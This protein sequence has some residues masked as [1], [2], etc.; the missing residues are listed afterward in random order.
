MTF[1]EMLAGESA[2]TIGLA[3]AVS[4]AVV[5]E[6]AFLR[7]AR[8]ELERGPD[9]GVE[10]DVWFSGFV[11]SRDQD[12]I[13]FYREAADGLRRRLAQSATRRRH[14]WALL[15]QAHADT[16]P[17]LQLEEEIGWLLTDEGDQ[18]LPKIKQRLRSAIAT[19][20][21]GERIGLAHWAV[22]AIHRLPGAVL[23]LE[24]TRIL[25][26]AAR[27]RLDGSSN[28][29]DVP[30]WMSWVLPTSQRATTAIRLRMFAGVLEM[31]PAAT[32]ESSP[33]GEVIRIPT[34]E[35]LAIELDAG[36]GP[37][38]VTLPI[39][40]PTFARIG[41]GTVRL[42]ACDGAVYELTPSHDRQSQRRREIISFKSLLDEGERFAALAEPLDVL[43]SASFKAGAGL[44]VTG[45]PGSGKTG[46]LI[47][48]V[49]TLTQQ[50]LAMHF[51]SDRT[52]QWRDADLAWTSLAAQVEEF[53]PVEPMRPVRPIE[54]LRRA[55]HRLPPSN[56]PFIVVIDGLDE[57]TPASRAR[58]DLV[59][60]FGDGLPPQACVV[61]SCNDQ[62]HISEHISDGQSWR[63]EVGKP[64]KRAQDAGME[65]LLRRLFEGSSSM[66]GISLDHPQWERARLRAAQ[67]S[68]VDAR[69]AELL[70]GNFLAGHL[71]RTSRSGQEG[72]MSVLAGTLRPAAKGPQPSD[73]AVVHAVAAAVWAS[74]PV[75]ARGLLR[76]L[77]A[78]R[79]PL[80]RFRIDDAAR[81]RVESSDSTFDTIEP[82]LATG[83]TPDADT[84]YIVRHQA[85]RTFI[86]GAPPGQNDSMLE[87]HE[88][89]LNTV[90]KWTPR[91]LGEFQKEYSLRYAVTHAVGTGD[92]QRVVELLT[93][94]DF[95][96][97]RCRLE[98]PDRFVAELR[99]IVDNDDKPLEETISVS[100]ALSD[101]LVRL[102]QDPSAVRFLAYTALRSSTSE[103]K[104]TGRLPDLRLRHA[105]PAARPEG[106]EHRGAVVGCAQLGAS[107]IISWSADGTLKSWRRHDL[108]LER[109][110]TG[111]LEAVTACHMFQEGSSAAP[112]G[113]TLLSG[114]RDGTVR[115]W[116]SEKSVVVTTH[117]AP[118]RGV[119]WTGDAVLS[120]D[121]AGVIRVSEPGKGEIESVHEHRGAVNVCA[122]EGQRVWSGSEDHTIR[123]WSGL[124]N[125][126]QRDRPPSSVVLSG[127]TGAITAISVRG[128]D[129]YAYSCSEDGTIRVWNPTTFEESGLFS[130]HTSAVLGCQSRPDSTLVSWSRDRTL[131]IWDLAQERDTI[132]MTGHEGAV[133]GASVLSS[134]QILSC[135]SD[136]TLRL[137]DGET[138]AP[139]AV[140]EGHS[141]AVNGALVLDETY[142]ISCSDDRSLVRWDP[143]IWQ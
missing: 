10:A 76:I 48:F 20:V 105:I 34:I 43:R 64:L 30:E 134:G 58:T 131:R 128:P 111:H 73:V 112:S 5:I 40:R 139:L 109:T 54:R 59:E 9:A 29:T 132:V 119:T 116:Q 38:S 53:L 62:S 84:T 87:S 74:L 8:L 124:I 108:S 75:E 90:A 78:A 102:R 32:S 100:R 23:E 118:V 15:Q 71:L 57:M 31:E 120:W 13:V 25:Y 47:A 106:R 35:P 50:P 103:P 89:L 39:G 98:S 4:L 80:T 88:A 123:V 95:L 107:N 83:R 51:F 60:L 137:W 56:T 28:E 93:N 136:G 1:D 126:S 92:G 129:Q 121:A 138:G 79:E 72:L 61:C 6:P 14:A 86:E 70:G 41:N 33:P 104:V 133:L 67:E 127:H 113:L 85:L 44:F 27:L 81:S 18:A 99:A 7:R 97:A 3:E 125:K 65:P 140:F 21:G 17:A 91:D 110:L 37:V 142:I 36:D 46:L 26:T 42:R 24:E 22:Q 63:E 52:H 12:G 143:P 130:G 11:A 82:W 55:L 141:A 135:S 114:S 49:R 2:A 96:E 115:I 68:G 122:I 19:L 77:A 94:L 101:G 117:D 45:L 66:A 16:S 69:A